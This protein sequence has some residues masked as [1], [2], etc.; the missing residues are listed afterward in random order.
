MKLNFLSIKN[1]SLSITLFLSLIMCD[2]FAQNTAISN[3]STEFWRPQVH[4]SPK[5]NWTND[6]NGLI[7]LNGYYH[8]FF[9]HNPKGNEWGNMSWGHARSKDLLHWE[10]LPVAISNAKEY[11]FSGCVVLDKNHV[12]G[13]GDPNKTLLIAIYTADFPNTREEQHLAFSNDEGLTWTK[14]DQNPV[15]NIDYKDFRDPNIIWHEK[16]NQFIMVVSKP[17]EFTVQFYGSKNLKN[18]NHLSDFGMQGD[19]D[20]IWECPALMELPME[21]QIGQKKWVLS[22]S[23]QGPIKKFVG[24]QYFIGRFDGTHFQNENPKDVKLYV[25][26]GKDFYAAIPFYNAPKNENIWLGWALSWQYAK[27]QPTFPWKG[28]MSSVRKLSLVNT[29]EG[30]RLKQ[31]FL[32]DLDRKAP[33]FQAQDLKVSKSKKLNGIQFLSN[34]TYVIDLVISNSKSTKWGLNLT[35]TKNEKTS[36]GFDEKD[37]NWFIDRTQSGLDLGNNFISN[38]KAPSI[39]G[40]Q[41]N[42]RIF[43]D[44]SIIEVLAQEGTVAISSL[45]FPKGNT[46][47]VELFTDNGETEIKQIR[48]WELK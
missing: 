16:S 38:D 20:M 13:L 12:S 41:K 8:V 48:I 29:A 4:F 9:Q 44:K 25:D 39:G 22:L 18:W 19:I 34:R 46:E 21:D 24:M 11:I 23:S 27:E 30:I 14:F 2:L 42:I 47:N 15:L 3:Q 5:K 36:I 37:L 43:V 31:K 45:R 35:S 26:Y 32:P 40:M 10:E 7:Y 33:D 1:L 6:P 17:K 28:Q